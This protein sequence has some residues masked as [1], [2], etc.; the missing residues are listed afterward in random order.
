MWGLGLRGRD[1]GVMGWD[2]GVCA[3]RAGDGPFD[4]T[5]LGFVALCLAVL[6]LEVRFAINLAIARRG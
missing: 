4:A 2:R 3:A 5:L 6:A 1:S